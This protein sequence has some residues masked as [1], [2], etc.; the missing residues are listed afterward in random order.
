MTN[1]GKKITIPANLKANLAKAAASKQA[2]RPAKAERQSLLSAARKAVE[3]GKLP[4]VLTF[5]SQANYSY[6]RHTEAMHAL[7]KQGDMK[8]LTAYIVAGT[9]TYARAL[10]GYRDLLV[11]HLK[12]TGA[13]PKKTATKK[14]AKAKA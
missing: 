3:A 4:G 2:K 7:A 9:N 13:K 10:K 5:T 8:A 11:Q 12:A 14:T 1:Q 6:N